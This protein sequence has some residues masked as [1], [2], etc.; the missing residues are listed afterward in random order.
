[1]YC[2]FLSSLTNLVNNSL[3]KLTPNVIKK[4]HHALTLNTKILISTTVIDLDNKKYF[5]NTESDQKTS[6]G[7]CDTE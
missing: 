6:E 1:M 5:L 4:V 3:K 2:S 7:S